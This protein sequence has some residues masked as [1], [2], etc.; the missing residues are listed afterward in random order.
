MSSFCDFI[1][2]FVYKS[3]ICIP[4]CSCVW[5]SVRMS[6]RECLDY[7]RSNKPIIQI[8]SVKCAHNRVWCR[9]VCLY[10]R[11]LCNVLYLRLSTSKC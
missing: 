1:K 9:V 10:K 8:I 11:V 4:V 2:K 3:V 7:V 6:V 5:M